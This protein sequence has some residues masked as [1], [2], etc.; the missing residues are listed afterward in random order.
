MTW[1]RPDP[2]IRHTPGTEYATDGTYV[3]ERFK[4]ASGCYRYRRAHW[5]AVAVDIEWADIEQSIWE[6]VDESDVPKPGLR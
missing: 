6:V 4:D 3:Y 1:L 2:S 5:S